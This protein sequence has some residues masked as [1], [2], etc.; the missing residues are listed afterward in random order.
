MENPEP[1]GPV[2]LFSLPEVVALALLPGVAAVNFDQCRYEAG[3]TKPTRVLYYGIDLSHLALRC[4]HPARWLA[5]RDRR[6]HRQTGWKA[7]PPLIGR[8]PGGA[9]RTRA[10]AAYPERLNRA[11]VK[12]VVARG[13]AA[14]PCLGP[15]S[16]TPV[17]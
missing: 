1:Q 9:Y 4:N 5:W 6:G 7:H 16:A 3:S 8:A 11:L 13:R 15:A 12:A 17:E 14:L 2:S 10:A